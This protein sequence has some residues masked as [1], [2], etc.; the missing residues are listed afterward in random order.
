MD[1]DWRYDAGYDIC[2]M[3][4][5]VLCAIASTV[6]S[7]PRNGKCNVPIT[8]AAMADM[9]M[10]L[11]LLRASPGR[12]ARRGVLTSRPARRDCRLRRRVPR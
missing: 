7:L 8:A 5:T 12:A 4:N 6:G 2:D 10:A 9:S 11:V 1:D 3:S